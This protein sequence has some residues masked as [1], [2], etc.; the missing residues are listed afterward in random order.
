MCWQVFAVGGVVVVVVVVCWF[1]AG[2]CLAWL[3]VVVQEDGD[4]KVALG[5]QLDVIAIQLDIFSWTTLRQL[6]DYQ[7]GTASRY[8]THLHFS[9]RLPARHCL[10]VQRIGIATRAR[11]SA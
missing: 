6:H 9:F 3:G 8:D 1:V 11:R 2:C 10:Q 4:G 7:L 5:R